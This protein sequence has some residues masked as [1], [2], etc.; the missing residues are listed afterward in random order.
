METIKLLRDTAKKNIMEYCKKNNCEDEYNLFE[1]ELI[2]LSDEH[3]T[4]L[5]IDFYIT[6]YNKSLNL[7]NYGI[8]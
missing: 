2:R 3:N 8:L 6:F 7:L 4:K 1:K 5:P